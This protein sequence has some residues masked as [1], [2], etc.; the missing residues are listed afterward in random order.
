MTTIS[1]TV[2]SSCHFRGATYKHTI[3]SEETM[4]MPRMTTGSYAQS[5]SNSG[6]L[7]VTANGRFR[8]KEHQI[9]GAT[10]FWHLK[11]MFSRVHSE[12]ANALPRLFIAINFHP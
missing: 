12:T 8:P 6:H 1:S 7:P 5:D 10:D 2:L 3:L 11:H 9:C 4:F